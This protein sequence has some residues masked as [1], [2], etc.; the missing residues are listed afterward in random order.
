MFE[1]K[2]L[3]YH[4]IR[5]CAIDTQPFID[6]NMVYYPSNLEEDEFPFIDLTDDKLEMK[7]SPYFQDLLGKDY[8]IAIE[9]NVNRIDPQSSFVQDNMD[10][11]FIDNRTG[12][13]L[14]IPPIAA[15]KIPAIG[16]MKEITIMPI[17]DFRD[18][19]EMMRNVGL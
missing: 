5:L 13:I 2:S 6:F 16:A 15:D 19:D 3:I 17:P 18:L 10:S 4:P 1:D 9:I 11:Y 12:N 8:K 7:I 14:C